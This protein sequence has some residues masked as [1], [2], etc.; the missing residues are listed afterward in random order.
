MQFTWNESNP[1][2]QKCVET[3]GSNEKE[4]DEETEVTWVKYKVQSPELEEKLKAEAWSSFHHQVFLQ[5]G[6]IS[7]YKRLQAD[8]I[9]SP[10]YCMHK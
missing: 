5:K 3:G 8:L 6:E 2:P 4:E 9:F 7:A 1:V 10:V